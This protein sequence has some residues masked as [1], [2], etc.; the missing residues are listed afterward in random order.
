MAGTRP[1]K[2]EVVRRR[3]SGPRRGDGAA[4]QESAI[5]ISPPPRVLDALRHDLVAAGLQE[6]GDL[7]VTEVSL[8]Y[9]EAE[10]TGQPLGQGEEVY[11][12]LSAADGTGQ[13]V[14]PRYFTLSKP[15][16]PDR[17]KD[18]GWTVTLRRAEVQS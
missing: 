14:A 18:L 12:R 13:G 6:V 2:A 4:G 11:W 8:T 16:W 1:F 5:T 17:E 15:P 10:L 7:I 9:T 3:W